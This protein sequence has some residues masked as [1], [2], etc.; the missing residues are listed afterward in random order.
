MPNKN[1]RRVLV[2][3]HYR[4][5]L[6]LRENRE[7]LGFAVYHWGILVAP[8][9]STGRGCYSFDVSDG[10]NLDP[11]SGVNR[12]PNFEWVLRAKTGVNP[13]PSSHLLG[14]VM[15]GKI[16]H[17]VS[18]E[19]LDALLRSIPLPRKGVSGENCVSWT[20]A[21]VA[22]LQEKGWAER[23]NID[24]FMDDS[25]AYAHQRMD[26]DDVKSIINYTSRPM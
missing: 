18:F 15:I 2:T 13:L 6:S 10:I 23:F 26:A 11:G 9:A 1:K 22:K 20:R 5:A 19:Q 3:L 4:G 16:S 17:D 14:R 21:A 25:L 24:C 8:K 12:N 7:R